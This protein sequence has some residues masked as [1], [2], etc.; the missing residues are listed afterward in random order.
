MATKSA[1]PSWTPIEKSDLP[2][3]VLRGEAYVKKHHKHYAER[4]LFFIA[5]NTN[6]NI[7][8]YD[9][10]PSRIDAY[11]LMI[12]KKHQ[13][14][15]REKGKLHDREELTGVET[16]LAYGHEVLPNG[17]LRLSATKDFELRMR[18]SRSSKE[19]S[20][21]FH[22]DAK[23]LPIFAIYV[24]AQS[25]FGIGLPIVKSVMAYGRHPATKKLYRMQLK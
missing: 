23:R 16:R 2:H 4:H 1:T 9:S 25:I 10:L 18:V 22:H 13:Q 6:G 20:V 19:I 21:A 15:A 5:R 12:D 11:W 14:K 7:V 17:H 24:E 8:M 3:C